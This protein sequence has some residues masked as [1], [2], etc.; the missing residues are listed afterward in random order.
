MQQIQTGV[1]TTDAHTFDR[2]SSW[3]AHNWTW[4]IGIGIAAIAFGVA[5]VGGAFAGM[6]VLAWLA[7]LYL[8]FMGVAELLVPVRSGGV[9][10]RRAGSAIAIA[11]GIVLLA[12]PGKTLT[13]LA[14]V[15]GIALTA[16]G[17]SSAVTALRRRRE[18][19]REPWG[20]VVG[21]GLAA[22][23]ILVMARPTGTVTLVGV[24]MGL[25][26]VVWGVVTALHALDLRRTG[27]RW[28]EARQ[29]ER[30]RIEVAWD[31]F[32]RAEGIERFATVERSEV[33]RRPPGS[34]AA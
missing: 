23:G 12:W 8:L 1:G 10:S 17:V 3:A 19:E 33:E 28:E 9:T 29:L 14:F 26:A 5:L 16:W 34:R 21:V 15:A 27:L 22:L 11:G 4:V 25:V 30:R 6:S 2:R 18:G 24:L 20:I 13:V 31:E 32:E 7:G